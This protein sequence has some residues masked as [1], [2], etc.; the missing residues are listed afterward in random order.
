MIYKKQFSIIRYF[1]LNF[2]NNPYTLDYLYVS[3][4]IINDLKAKLD[5]I[6]ITY[7]DRFLYVFHSIYSLSVFNK[8]NKRRNQFINLK[9]RYIK[10]II[11]DRYNLVVDF[12]VK[13][14]FIETDNHFI[15]GFKS[16]GY[17]LAPKYQDCKFRKQKTYL[18]SKN[19]ID[20]SGPN[21]EFL[22]ENVKKVEILAKPALKEVRA[23]HKLNNK[24]SHS[25]AIARE[26][27]RGIHTKKHYFTHDPKTG[28]VYNLLVNAPKAIRKHLRIDGEALEELDIANSQ[29]LLLNSLY[30]VESPE[31]IK[32]KEITEKFDLYDYLVE[33]S[34]NNQLDRPAVK[35]LLY[36]FLFGKRIF[37]KI[38][39]ILDVFRA[40]FPILLGRINQIKQKDHRN[41]PML[42]Q[43]NEAD[44]IINN[45][46]NFAREKN[47][48]LFTIHDSFMLKKKDIELIRKK[49]IEVF[50][51]KFNVT[52]VLR[53][54]VDKVQESV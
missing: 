50:Q 14:G 27:I 37:P 51:S 29:P 49:T 16:R 44:A 24:S 13:E 1:N 33:K 19:P 26:H 5:E 34:Y 12:L 35:K 18:R 46:V 32:F 9:A 25:L 39:P 15:L 2:G 38:Q 22:L 53:S 6:D 30:L 36:T 21:H 7:L 45:V 43:R 11:G 52:P 8:T 23:D 47:I 42:L 54:K 40:E 3:D 4:P 31:S 48:F 20:L 10:D 41:L 28:R 17:K